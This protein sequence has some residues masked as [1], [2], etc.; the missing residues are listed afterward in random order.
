MEGILLNSFSAML[1]PLY[2]VGCCGPEKLAAVLVK[3]ENVDSVQ[4]WS[5]FDAN[6]LGMLRCQYVALQ[7]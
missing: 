6:R 7:V 5:M 1:L 2:K 4:M 3:M